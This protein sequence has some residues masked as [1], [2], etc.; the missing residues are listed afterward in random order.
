MALQIFQKFPK[1]VVSAISHCQKC[2][3][4][5]LGG[6]PCRLQCPKH[7][8]RQ[9]FCEKSKF[10]GVLDTIFV[11]VHRFDLFVRRPYQESYSNV[12]SGGNFLK[13]GGKPFSEMSRYGLRPKFHENFVAIISYVIFKK[14]EFS[15]P[16]GPTVE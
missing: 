4:D 7:F 12:K 9:R 14:S 13:I 2:T 16:V 1:V 8:V 5:F 15:E 10:F 3:V 11:G 6:V